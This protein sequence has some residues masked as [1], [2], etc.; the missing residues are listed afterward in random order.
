LQVDL[1]WHGIRNDGV[2]MKAKTQ[3]TW[4]VADEPSERFAKVESI[5]VSIL[6]PFEVIK[7]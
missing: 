5:N 3:H 4:T 6:E 7:D 2:I 1:D